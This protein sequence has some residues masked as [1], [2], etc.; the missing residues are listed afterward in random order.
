MSPASRGTLEE[1]GCVTAVGRDDDDDDADLPENQLPTRCC[2]S[3]AE[4]A[5]TSLWLPLGVRVTGE[6]KAVGSV[7]LDTVGVDNGREEDDSGLCSV[8]D[9]ATGAELR[10]EAGEGVIRT[11]SGSEG[12]TGRDVSREAVP[13][14]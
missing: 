9:A 6:S 1:A 11:L 5:T 4:Y 10:L 14:A 8:V 7:V 13:S 12:A 3:G 2:A